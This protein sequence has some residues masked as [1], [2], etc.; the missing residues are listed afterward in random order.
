MSLEYA[1]LGFLNYGPS[2][3]YDLKKLFDGSVR[4]FWPADQSQIYRTLSR[5][6]SQGFISS[7]KVIQEDRPNQKV[8]SLTEKGREMLLDWL[9]QSHPHEDK[10]YSFLIQVFFAGQ[11]DDDEILAIFEKRAE[12][13]RQRLG[14]FHELEGD[15]KERIKTHPER[16][17]FYWMLTLEHGIWVEKSILKWLEN[18]IDRIKRRDYGSST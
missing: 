8:Y 11:L 6:A 16:D 10:R 7:R 18:V 14:A 17:R 2:T 4:H 15:V 12:E 9:S 5:L 1:I 13:L 3:G